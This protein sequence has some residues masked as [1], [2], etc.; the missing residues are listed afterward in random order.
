MENKI[1]VIVAHPDDEV[2]GCG[3]TIAKNTA[4]GT[5]VKI[6]YIADGESSRTQH[7]GSDV[8]LIEDRL[9]SA[10]DSCLKLGVKDIVSLDYPDQMLDTI[11]CLTIT[12]SL[13]EIIQ[14]FKPSIVL[15]HSPNDLNLDHR[16]TSNAVMTAC[17]PLPHSSVR[18]IFA[19]EVLSSTEWA[20]NQYSAFVPTVYADIT[21]HI[22]IKIDALT[23]YDNEMRSFPHPRSYQAVRALAQYRGAT[24]GCEY[25]EAFQ[26]IRYIL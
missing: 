11:P 10:R 26:L 6:I 20:V 5:E 4:N 19:F 13:E 2:L 21:D 16:I 23:S 14:E 22:D 3:G 8:G 18:G 7:S 17:R 1:L 24:A 12:Q 9:K 25:A 15:T